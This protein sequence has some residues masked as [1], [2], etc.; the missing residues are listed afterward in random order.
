MYD[1][2]LGNNVNVMKELATESIDLVV[3][4]PPYD[5]LRNY[6]NTCDWN[7]EVFKLVANELY[8]LM[9][10]G[11]VIIW[12]VGDKTQDGSESGTSFKQALYFKEIGFNLHDTML[13]RKI[14][15]MPTSG[16]RYGQEFEY[17]FCFSKGKPKTFNPLKLKCKYG[18][19][20]HWGKVS[21]YK[22][23]NDDLT[24]SPNKT[25]INETKNRG[26]IFEYRVG[27]TETGDIDHPAMFPL[28]LAED[29]IKTWS[30]KGDLILD[31]F[32]GSGTT[33]IASIDLDRNFIGIDIV[34]KYY[35][36]AKQRLEKAEKY[37]KMKL[38]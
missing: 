37:S 5:D 4:S 33:G 15:Y 10:Q 32:M 27:S 35:N 19:M 16:D 6:D 22:T 18:G 29:Q 31:P 26:N 38:F 11:G 28:K 1:I 34:Q 9:K 20:T 25:L 36:I 13:Y 12:V 23:G 2:K 7:F 30:N 24:K 17:M 3:T 8:R 21:F 14:N